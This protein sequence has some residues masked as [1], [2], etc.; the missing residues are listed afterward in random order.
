M[1]DTM[2]GDQ[3]DDPADSQPYESAP[4]ES[5]QLDQDQLQSDTSLVDRGVA[6]AL[7]EGYNPPEG[8][9][10]GQGFG[11]TAAEQAAGET[12]DQRLAQE[13]PDVFE[14]LDR[15]PSPDGSGML[16]PDGRTLE[17]ET[18]DDGEVGDARAGRLMEPNQG[19]GEDVDKDL[20]GTDVGI[21]AGAATAEEAAMHIVDE[22]RF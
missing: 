2:T 6:D 14:T 21:D 17:E 22:D 18:L 7:D 5:E 11:N 15:E 4:E 13:E 8:Y 16:D 10:A 9:S 20:I 19:I 3:M 12:L 1:T